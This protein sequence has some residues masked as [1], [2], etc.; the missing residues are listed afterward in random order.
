MPGALDAIELGLAQRRQVRLDAVDETVAVYKAPAGFEEAVD[1]AIAGEDLFRV[2]QVVE[3]DCGDGEIE[4]T[5]DLLR[6]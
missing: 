6:P 3:R 4:G 5:A 1:R 2:A